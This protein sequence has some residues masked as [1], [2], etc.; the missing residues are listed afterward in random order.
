MS[1]VTDNIQLNAGAGGATIATDHVSAKHYQI[2]KTAYGADGTALDVTRTVPFPVSIE[3]GNGDYANPYIAVAGSTNGLEP[4]MVS[5][6]G[7]MTLSI[8]TIGV[9]GGT[10]GVSR[11][12]D[13]VSSDLRSISSGLTIGVATIGTGTVTVTSGV[14]LGSPAA[15][16]YIGDVDI[17]NTTLPS[18]LTIG[19]NLTVNTS[20]SVLHNDYA[21]QSGVRVKNVGDSTDPTLYISNLGGDGFYHLEPGENIFLEINNINLIKVKASATN[22][23]VSWIGS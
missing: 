14:V 2:V 16:V 13:G 10:L 11:V 17:R 1:D 4:I 20:S 6:T 12:V 8:N 23:K 15:D 5:V 19:E 18:T 7:G 9:S 22:G 21:L 3:V